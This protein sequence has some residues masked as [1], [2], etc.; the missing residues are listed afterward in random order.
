M[1][2]SS[3]KLAHTELVSSV[4]ETFDRQPGEA[5]RREHIVSNKPQQN[6]S[7]NEEITAD[8]LSPIRKCYQSKKVSNL[9][10]SALLCGGKVLRNNMS[11]IPIDGLN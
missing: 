9:P 10:T 2:Y 4:N 7:V 11:L 3:P 5:V 6:S 8:S 1:Y